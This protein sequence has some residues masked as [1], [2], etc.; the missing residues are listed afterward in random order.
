MDLRR[1]TTALAAGMLL[2]AGLTAPSAT[3]AASAAEIEARADAALERLVDTAPEA[4][5]LLERARGVLVFPRVLKAGFGVGGEYGEGV[6]RRDGQSV[7]Y[8]STA[9]A[10]IGFQLGAQSKA[11][12][13]LFMTDESLEDFRRADG[14][15]VGVDASVTLLKIGAGGS[16]DT[17]NVANPVVGFVLA[18]RG[19]MYDASLAGTKIS[20]IQRD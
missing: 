20:R 16:V 4:R 17:T 5:Q 11:Q 18:D 19:L 1:L 10:S 6:L 9:S 8:Y 13:L 15:E 3:R 7:E 12:F 2:L 14:W